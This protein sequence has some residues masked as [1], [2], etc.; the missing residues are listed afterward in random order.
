MYPVSSAS[1]GDVQYL[2]VSHSGVRLVRR[3]K[4]LPTDYLQVG[5]KSCIAFVIVLATPNNGKPS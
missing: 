5:K 1:S 2:A 4:S 3:E